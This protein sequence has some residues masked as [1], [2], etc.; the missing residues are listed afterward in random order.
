[1]V[2]DA[3]FNNISHIVAVIFIGGGNRSTRRKPP[4]CRKLY[5]YICV[6]V[7]RQANCSTI[8]LIY[9]L[10][11]IVEILDYNKTLKGL[12]LKDITV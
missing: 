5:I 1:M 6:C 9:L 7:C 4:V 3:T 8:I 11:S 10:Y 2:F 12:I